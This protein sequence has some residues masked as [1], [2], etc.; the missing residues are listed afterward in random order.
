MTLLK[1]T[2]VILLGWQATA[3]VKGKYASMSDKEL[4]EKQN[5]CDSIPKKSAVFANGR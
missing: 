4:A 3:C 2:F 5:H 1:I